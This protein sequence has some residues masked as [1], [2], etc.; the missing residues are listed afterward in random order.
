MQLYLLMCELHLF[1]YLNTFLLVLPQVSLHDLILLFLYL[2]LFLLDTHHILYF[3]LH[4]LILFILNSL[5]KLLL[6]VCQQIL[7]LSLI[8]AWLFQPHS[9]LFLI[10]CLHF[11]HLLCLPPSL[12]YFLQSFVLLLLKHLYPIMQFNN[13]SLYLLSILPSLV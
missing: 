7:H 4:Q 9:C 3:L 5:P 10:Q 12:V 1:H 13:I 11:D 2:D 6:P 8:L